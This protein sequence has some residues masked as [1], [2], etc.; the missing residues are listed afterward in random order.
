MPDDS[1]IFSKD[2]TVPLVDA[3]DTTPPAGIKLSPAEREKFIEQALDDHESPLIGYASSIL[4]DADL[5]RDVVQD[6]F[7]RLC[8]QEI[9]RVD[10]NVKAWLFTVCRN[11]ALDV[12]R[13]EKR[14]RPLEEIRWE[15]VAG[16]G[17]QP[18]EKAQQDE[19]ATKLFNHL[20][21]LTERQREVVMLKYQQ[22]LS[23]QEIHRITGLTTGNVAVIL[24]TALKRLREIIR[25]RDAS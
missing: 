23:Y 10:V 20:N 17:L 18:D 15:K 9:E 16:P 5:A 12:L 21:H 22:D 7:I 1:E 4:H 6:A 3:G 8:E 11:L 19:R 25:D 2:S 13:K 14:T 24:H